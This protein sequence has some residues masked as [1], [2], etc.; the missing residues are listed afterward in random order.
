MAN[1]KTNRGLDYPSTEHGQIT[2]GPGGT[3]NDPMIVKVPMDE[4]D[5]GARKGILTKARQPDS[6]GNQR[7]GIKHV[8]SKK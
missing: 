8:E 7:L 2:N 4:V 6:G 1:F 3:S 5:W